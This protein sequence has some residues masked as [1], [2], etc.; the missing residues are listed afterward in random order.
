MNVKA[1]PRLNKAKVLSF[2][3]PWRD[4]LG[5]YVSGIPIRLGELVLALFIPFAFCGKKRIKKSEILI[6]VLFTFKFNSKYLWIIY[7]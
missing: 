6:V 7:K 5:F 4:S 1:K 2:I 3:Y